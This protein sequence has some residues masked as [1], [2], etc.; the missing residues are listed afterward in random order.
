MNK[1]CARLVLGFGILFLFPIHISAAETNKGLERYQTLENTLSFQQRFFEDAKSRGVLVAGHTETMAEFRRAVE[2]VRQISKDKL[3]LKD[4]EPAE[5]AL[6]RLEMEFVPPESLAILDQEKKEEAKTLLSLPAAER[7]YWKPGVSTTSF[8]RFG[9]RATDGLLCDSV[10][11]E[12]IKTTAT[13]IEL[14]RVPNAD[15][16]ISTLG[17]DISFQETSIGLAVA[18]PDV[19]NIQA[20]VKS[21]NWIGKVLALSSAEQKD[22]GTVATTL[23]RPA[24]RFDYTGPG[25]AFKIG[26]INLEKSTVGYMSSTGLKFFPLNQ[27]GKQF[28]SDGLKYPWVV[29]DLADAKR[30]QRILVVIQVQ[31]QMKE[32]GITSEGLTLTAQKGLL[33]SFWVFRPWGILRKDNKS[34]AEISEPLVRKINDMCRLNLSWP[35]RCDE[36]YRMD[37]KDQVVQILNSVAAENLTDD[38]GTRPLEAAAIPPMVMLAQ[39][40]SAPVTIQGKVRNWDVPTRYGDFATVEGKEVRYAIPIPPLNRHGLFA[41]FGKKEFIEMLNRYVYQQGK[42]DG[43]GPDWAYLGV[44]Q[45]LAAWPYLNTESKQLLARQKELVKTNLLPEHHW[46]MF[47][48][49]MEPYSGR[50]YCFNYPYAWYVTGPTNDIN[51]G[52]TLTFYGLDYWAAF[53]G[54]WKEIEAAWPRIW[55]LTE[56]LV[57]SHDWAW[58]ADSITEEGLGNAID[59]LTADY[60]GLVGIT[61]LA[62]TLGKNDEADRALYLT[63]KTALPH[64]LRFPYL[65]YVQKCDMWH[66]DS[67]EIATVNGFHEHDCFLHPKHEKVSWWGTCSLGYGIN[68]ECFDAMFSYIRRPA[69]MAWW[70]MVNTIYPKWYDGN[71]WLPR[72]G[73]AYDGN[74]GFVV[75]DIIYLQFRF[76]VSDK[77][78]FSWLVNH[79]KTRHTEGYFQLPIV[80][81]EILSR[82]CPVQVADWGQCTFD[83]AKYDPYKKIAEAVFTNNNSTAQPIILIGQKVP[84]K[85]LLGGKPLNFTKSIDR[86]NRT[87]VQFDLPAGNHTITLS[88]E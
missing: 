74:S 47:K 42:I 30:P 51:W 84:A 78:L 58:M 49:R 76:G 18:P 9:W 15:R 25:A 20:R 55:P 23:Q 70:E 57:K 39:R 11:F 19:K 13:E 53:G 65:E 22:L 14:G 7:A 82:D 35:V 27:K 77:Q 87:L 16:Q 50:R 72:T 12:S 29:L 60:A 63:A 79:E 31:R 61:R 71:L 3:S 37:S 85:L 88:F 33:G 28:L 36:F 34:P 32:I 73:P 54:M 26:G 8:G 68:P 59:C 41:D 4:L 44:A 17:C 38:W 10:A 52:N 46:K 62:R 83:Q 2:N 43:A 75:L 48:W 81:G 69:L 66:I 24:T 1:K 21:V 86:W 6:S 56:Y 45:A 80:L 64:T 5:K 67:P 40:Y